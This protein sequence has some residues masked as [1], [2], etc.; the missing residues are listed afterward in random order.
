MQSFRIRLSSMTDAYRTKDL[1]QPVCNMIR[2]ESGQNTHAKGCGY[3][4]YAKGDLF[5]VKKR[6]QQAKIRYRF[7]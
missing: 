2:I 5:E 4:I 3:I 1:L 6:L 7:D